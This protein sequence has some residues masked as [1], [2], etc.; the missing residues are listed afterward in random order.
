MDENC[1]SI[2]TYNRNCDGCKNGYALAQNK[3]DCI[4][5]DENKVA[6]FGKCIDKI[7][8]CKIYKDEKNCEICEENYY[9]SNGN[10]EICPNDQISK[11]KICYEKITICL[12][13]DDNGVCIE[14]DKDG[15]YY[16]LNAEGN[17]CTNCE[18][19]KVSNRVKCFNE[20][21]NCFNYEFKNDEAKCLS[22]KGKYG[23]TLD[24]S[25]CI[26][27]ENGQ[28][29]DGLN[30]IDESNKI[31]SCQFYS[32]DGKCIKYSKYHEVVDGKC[33][34]CMR[35]FTSEGN[36]CYRLR[37]FCKEYNEKGECILCQSGFKLN[38]E[39]NCEAEETENSNNNKDDS[40]KGE[41]NKEKSE[42][43]DDKNLFK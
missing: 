2:S 35:T 27:C 38:A 8:N 28:F 34:V 3:I 7:E 4:K 40:N 33:S 11:G 43:E 30:C 13:Y 39:G 10:C 29:F 41:N 17:K 32:E 37:A 22:C 21:K 25:E 26:L 19:G 6:P 5:C 18:T 23:V 20:I 12:N 15:N 1:I 36:I 16:E 24:G 9:I 31:D 14:C 42:T